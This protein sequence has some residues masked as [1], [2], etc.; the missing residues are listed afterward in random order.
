METTILLSKV[1]GIFLIICGAV[2]MIRREYFI[3]LIS[4]F[5]RERLTRLVMS[6]IELVAGLFLIFTHNDFS[7]LPAGIISAFGWIAIIESIIYFAAPDRTLQKMLSR[8]NSPKL[9]I[10]GGLASI[11]LGLYLASFGLGLI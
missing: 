10:F 6:I 3:P 9:Y 8:M 1:L 4:S 11:A 7:S 5:V 2:V